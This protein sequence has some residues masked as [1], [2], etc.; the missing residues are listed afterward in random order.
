MRRALSILA[1]ALGLA[2]GTLTGCTTV[3]S[4]HAGASPVGEGI[5]YNLPRAHFVLSVVEAGGSVSVSLS[6][7]RMV[8]DERGLMHA[9]LPRNGLSDDNVTISVDSHTNLLAKVEVTS[10]GRLTDI[11]TNLARSFAFLQGAETRSGTVIFQ[12]EFDPADY[13]AT[14]Q[15]ANEALRGYYVRLCTSGLRLES[16][17]FQDELQRAGYP[18]D[19]GKKA[20]RDRLLLCRQLSAAGVSAVRADLITLTLDDATVASLRNEAS[21]TAAIAGQCARGVC[22]RP[23]RPVRFTLRVGDYYSLSDTFL[24]PDLSRIVFVNLG[25]GIF[26][27]QKYSLTFSDGVLTSYQQDAHS[28]LVGLARLP[29]E[30]VGAVISSTTEALGFRQGG[31]EAEND[32]LTAVRANVDQQNQTATVCRTTPS[33]CPS[34]AFRVMRVS[35]TPRQDPASTLRTTGGAPDI[36]SNAAGAAGSGGNAPDA[37]SEN[38]NASANEVMPDDGGR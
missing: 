32:Y 7:P 38:S 5:S 11:A 18:D 36:G 34:T 30:V 15:Q 35:L 23:L 26:A 33:A 16:Q 31:L 22:Y 1:A 25:A 21:S 2:G 10:V 12:G 29:A 20:L 17:P 9:R 4:R 24:M 27:Q 3:D 14:V 37:A 13:V 19:E 28:E 8:P 6:G